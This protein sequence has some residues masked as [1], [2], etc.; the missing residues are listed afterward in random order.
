[1]I[2]RPPRSTRT[3]TLFPYTSLFR[4]ERRGLAST[5]QVVQCGPAELLRTDRHG[6]RVV[7]EA[8]HAQH[9]FPGISELG[10]LSRIGADEG[11]HRGVVGLQDR[12]ST[13]L[14]SSH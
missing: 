4:S 10:A 6:N 8:E 9:V 5:E 3:D 7:G 2:W 14:N 11:Q 1:M 12:K 13:R